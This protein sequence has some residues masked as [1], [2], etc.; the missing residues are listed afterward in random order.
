MLF[1]GDDEASLEPA[2]RWHRRIYRREE[3][4]ESLKEALRILN[5]DDLAALMQQ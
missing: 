1:P 4:V 3:E 2:D 5:G